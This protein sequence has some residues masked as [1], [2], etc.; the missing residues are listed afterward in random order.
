M[1]WIR[2][3]NCDEND[4]N[5][6]SEGG[7]SDIMNIIAARYNFTLVAD[8]EPDGNWGSIPKTGAWTDPNATFEGVLG[9]VVDS[10]YDMS[11]VEWKRTLERSRWVNYTNSLL[12]HRGIIMA[13]AV[14]AAFDVGLFTRPFTTPSWIAIGLSCMVLFACLLIP[15]KLLPPNSSSSSISFVSCSGWTFFLLVNA[16]YGGALT[17]F[18]TSEP[19]PPFETTREGLGLFPDWKMIMFSG[20]EINIQSLAEA[21]DPYYKTYWD[22]VHS[23][24]GRYLEKANVTEALK[25]LLNTGMFTIG[26]EAF[27]ISEVVNNPIK[28][29]R[30]IRT[31]TIVT[32]V[33]IVCK[34]SYMYVV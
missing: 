5:C 30:T 3:F 1:P 13:N 8:K 12:P 32:V 25:A 9:R 21:G 18:F 31:I 10:S 2:L 22:L 17:M 26:P 29:T 14:V 4:R 19:R 27:L 20:N 6:E 24:E 11:I 23:E 33:L 34:Y 28:G 16:F 15:H 7:N